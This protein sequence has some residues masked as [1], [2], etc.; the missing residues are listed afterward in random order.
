MKKIYHIII[1]ITCFKVNAQV[2][3]NEN[4]DNFGNL[5][6][7]GW[8]I[9]NSSEP[10]GSNSWGTTTHFAPYNGAPGSFAAVNYQS[11]GSLGTISNWLISPVINLK[12]GD[13]VSFYSRTDHGIWPDRLELRISLNGATSVIPSP[14]SNSL[15]DFTTLALTINPD[16]IA[17]GYPTV[18]TNYSY[19][20]SGLSQPTD[21]RIGFRYYVTNAGSN[22][23][24]GDL[25]GID[26]LNVTNSSL[27]NT[28]FKTRKISLFPNPTKEYLTV[29]NLDSGMKVE[30]YD[31][32]GKKIK[33]HKVN[34]D[35]LDVSNLS[36]GTYLIKIENS[37]NNIETLKFMKY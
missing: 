21:C 4:F 26:A 30:I 11:T 8:T 28:D 20:V 1:V 18:W 6:T 17:S 12:N 7:S 22:G 35:T 36:K 16:L 5:M 2:I 15:G 13:I 29:D 27:N 3:F 23:D 10:M 34:N 24:N 25:I 31:I 9:Q 37:D 33:Y 14:S 19:T 32:Q